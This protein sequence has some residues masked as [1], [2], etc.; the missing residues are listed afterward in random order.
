MKRCSLLPRLIRH[1]LL[2]VT[3]RPANSQLKNG[4]KQL[5]TLAEHRKKRMPFWLS[6]FLRSGVIIADYRE[7]P[8]FQTWIIN[9]RESAFHAFTKGALFFS[10][11]M[12]AFLFLIDAV[13]LQLNFL[14]I[15]APVLR[16][17]SAIRF[18]ENGFSDVIDANYFYVWQLKLA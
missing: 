9:F 18:E 1:L 5:L 10:C 2:P 4:A 3:F 7:R 11:Y 16:A 12:E 13:F 15:G 8:L 6:S 17:V 14:P